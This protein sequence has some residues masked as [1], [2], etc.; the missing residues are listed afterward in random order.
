[1]F[2]FLTMC[3]NLNSRPTGK[4]CCFA[5]SSKELVL[6]PRKAVHWDLFRVGVSIG[7]CQHLVREG[8]INTVKGLS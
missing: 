2:Y 1:M 8:V 6:G 4:V 5:V 3:N 7:S